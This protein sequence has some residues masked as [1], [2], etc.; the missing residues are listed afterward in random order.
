MALIVKSKNKYYLFNEIN[1]I[2]F[3][4]QN[5]FGFIEKGFE[6][7]GAKMYNAQKYIKQSNRQD[8]IGKDI[9]QKFLNDNQSLISLINNKS[10]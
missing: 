5:N 3:N 2:I 4:R 1:T 10:K 7:I 8:T 6:N 9:K